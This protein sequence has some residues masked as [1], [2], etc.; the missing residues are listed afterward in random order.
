MDGPPRRPPRR[1]VKQGRREVLVPVTEQ[2]AEV[3]VGQ[4]GT[5]DGPPAPPCRWSP[6]LVDISSLLAS[7][8][9]KLRNVCRPS[10]MS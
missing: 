5:P 6:Q 2:A 7:I 4:F 8:F 1:Q 9:L 3:I 10:L